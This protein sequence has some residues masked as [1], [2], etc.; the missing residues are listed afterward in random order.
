MRPSRPAPWPRS[1]S[2]TSAKAGRPPLST[3]RCVP[4]ARRLNAE[5]AR[6]LA[7]SDKM[8]R[9]GSP[10]RPPRFRSG[11]PLSRGSALPTPPGRCPPDGRVRPPAA[12]AARRGDCD[13][14]VAG[15]ARALELRLVTVD[16]PPRT[17]RRFD[18]MTGNTPEPAPSIPG[19]R[20]TGWGSM[21]RRRDG[22][23]RA[24]PPSSSRSTGRS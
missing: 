18:A 14:R 20:R 4:A 11:R 2:P 13:V 23:G 1:D 6:D 22:R 10:W 21:H 9:H 17:R 8:R 12:R 24:S 7:L 16:Q 5:Q 19:R 3:C 15:S